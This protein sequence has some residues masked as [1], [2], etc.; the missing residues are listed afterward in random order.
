MGRFDVVVFLSS[1][2]RSSRNSLLVL[3]RGAR[4][5][6]LLLLCLSATLG[7]TQGAFAQVAGAGVQPTESVNGEITLDTLNIHIDIPIMHKA[8]IGLP[9]SF[10]LHYNSNLWGITNR[11]WAPAPAINVA[12]SNMGLAF[13]N[14]VSLYGHL[15][16][17]TFGCGSSLYPSFSGY[18]DP[19]GNYHGYKS[20]VGPNVAVVLSPS[21][22]TIGLCTTYSS[23]SIP[24]TDGS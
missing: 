16:G 17:A 15:V 1:R 23:V 20:P 14:L 22:G 12:T 8:G 21:G 4:N 3:A 18:V 6:L 7:F 24:L 9:L 10:G 2:V 5:F 11:V 19:A 13:S